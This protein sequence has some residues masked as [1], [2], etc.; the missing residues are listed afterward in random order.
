MK[1]NFIIFIEW[2]K[3]NISKG[4]LFYELYNR[5]VDEEEYS[6]F[7]NLRQVY[8]WIQEKSREASDAQWN[9]VLIQTYMIEAKLKELSIDKETA[10]F[11]KEVEILLNQLKDICPQLAKKQYDL[12]KKLIELEDE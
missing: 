7:L 2:I 8:L 11:K 10:N 12:V 4:E 3:Q 1:T 5:L 6:V 9:N